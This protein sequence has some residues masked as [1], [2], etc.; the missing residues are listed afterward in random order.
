MQQFTKGSAHNNSKILFWLL[1]NKPRVPGVHWP[2]SPTLSVPLT[3][4][5]LP[6]TLMSL[7]LGEEQLQE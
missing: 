2:T 4:R 5:V 7:A 1:D 3:Q 6:R